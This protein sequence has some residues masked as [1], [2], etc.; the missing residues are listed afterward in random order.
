MTNYT[1]IIAIL[2]QMKGIT[3]KEL[4]GNKMSRYT[5]ERLIKGSGGKIS[6]T[7]FIYIIDKLHVS[8]DEFLQIGKLD[9]YA[10]DQQYELHRH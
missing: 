1:E 8:F 6:L 10:H 9:K 4:I 2:R 3:I 5:Y 7:N